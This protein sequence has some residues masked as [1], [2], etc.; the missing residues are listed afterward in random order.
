MD[1]TQL[2]DFAKM[3][4]DMMEHQRYLHFLAFSTYQEDD[5]KEIPMVFFAQVLLPKNTVD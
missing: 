4:L 1:E 2:L 3:Q 5:V